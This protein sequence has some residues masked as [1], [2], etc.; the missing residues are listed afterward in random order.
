MRFDVLFWDMSSNKPYNYDSLETDSLGGTEATTIRLAE[1]F[2]TK[3]VKV[4][5]ITQFDGLPYSSPAGVSYLPP[6]WKSVIR[7]NTVIHLRSRRDLELFKTSKNIIWMHDA[8]GLEH[9]NITDWVE[10]I[11]DTQ[12]IAVSDWHVKNIL[13][14]CPKLNVKRIYSPV[15]ENCYTHPRVEVDYNQL[16]WMASPHKGLD[17]ALELFSES[18]S[19][20]PKLR[21]AVFNPGYFNG[22]KRD[23]PGVRY[24]SKANRGDMRLIVS[25]SLALFYPTEFE[26]TFGLIA[27]EAEALGVPCITNPVAALAESS[28][29]FYKVEDISQLQ[30]NRPSITG[31]LR[32][33]FDNIW[34][35]WEEIL[36]SGSKPVGEDK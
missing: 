8:C 1:G 30:V 17:K 18:R 11:G 9:N 3:G 22:T 24:I 25:S 21:L 20:L 14:I 4:A 10:Y 27:A 23:L 6:R 32:F 2:A 36:A 19:R 12:C 7:P 5:V 34:P 15:D 31:Q 13:S 33:K 35:D 26:E 28:T 29:T 16:V